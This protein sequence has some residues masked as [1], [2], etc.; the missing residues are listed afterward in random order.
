VERRDLSDLV[1]SFTVERPRFVARLRQ[2]AKYP[3]RLLVC[4]PSCCAVLS[5]TE[6]DNHWQLARHT[7][8]VE[9]TKPLDAKKLKEGDQVD[10]E[11]TAEPSR[12]AEYGL[13]QNRLD[14]P[15]SFP[16]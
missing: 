7:F 6:R 1:R 4:C 8:T 11:L 5:G 10:T 16:K 9:L 3:H 12:R 2:M 15:R 14:R 13:Q